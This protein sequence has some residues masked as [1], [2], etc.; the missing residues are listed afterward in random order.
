MFCRQTSLK[1]DKH[2]CDRAVMDMADYGLLG[3][4]GTLIAIFQRLMARRLPVTSLQERK[5][6]PQKRTKKRPLS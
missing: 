3:F 2:R 5:K 6:T 4:G 1:R